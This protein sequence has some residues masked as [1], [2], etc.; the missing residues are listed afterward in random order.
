MEKL[1][2]IPLK[3]NLLLR[4]FGH[5]GNVEKYIRKTYWGMWKLSYERAQ[6]Y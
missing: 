5:L 6:A 1:Y 4:Y 2:G 3:G